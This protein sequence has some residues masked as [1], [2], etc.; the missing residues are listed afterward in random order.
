MEGR[1]KG[2][3]PMSFHKLCR[4]YVLISIRHSPLIGKRGIFSQPTLL[5]FKSYTFPPSY[6][7]LHLPNFHLP[8]DV[9]HS[10]QKYKLSNIENYNL[11]VDVRQTSKRKHFYIRNLIVILGF[12]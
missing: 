2:A 4:P 7:L 8:L 1:P 6:T 9:G 5:V 10:P 3:N 12:Y 11:L